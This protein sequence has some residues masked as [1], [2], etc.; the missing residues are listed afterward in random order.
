MIFKETKRFKECNKIVINYEKFRLKFTFIAGTVFTYSIY[1]LLDR[2]RIKKLKKII[3]SYFNNPKVKQYLK[4]LL[5]LNYYNINF[6]D[7]MLDDNKNNSITLITDPKTFFAEFS[8]S[9]DFSLK[10]CLNIKKNIKFVVLIDLAYTQGLIDET[11]RDNLHNFREKR[12]EVIHN[13][14]Y[15]LSPEELD[16]TLFNIYPVIEKLSETISEKSKV[17]SD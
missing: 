7:K 17:V 10:F 8:N 16:L 14:N 11:E 3:F 6:K 5:T 4:V 1:K 12:N 2:K 15:I 13:N 9:I